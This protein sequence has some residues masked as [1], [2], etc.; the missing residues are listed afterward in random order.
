MGT[1][2]GGPNSSFWP[3]DG[4]IIGKDITWFHCVIWPC[5]LKSAGVPLN[6]SVFSHGFVTGKNGEKMSKSIGNVIDANDILDK[7]GADPFRFYMILQAPYGNDLAF[8]EE[9][10]KEMNDSILCSKFGNLL[11]RAIVLAQK[12]FGGKIPDVS[13][14]MFCDLQKLKRETDAA[15]K[16]FDLQKACQ[17][18]VNFL[19][20]A[21]TYHKEAKP[22]NKGRSDEERA[23]AVKT[24]VEAVYIG[25][26]FLAPYCPIAVDKTF[27]QLGV[28]QTT[29]KRL[30]LFNNIP[31]GLDLGSERP[32]VLFEQFAKRHLKKAA[33]AGAAAL[34]RLF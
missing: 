28:P 33:K 24:A 30:G 10:L 9:R 26:H 21:N 3:P 4:Q 32:K 5:M 25:A 27:K 14:D 12:Y 6:R 11:N 15:F 19:S 29:I 7:Y 2:E 22:W 20:A 31:A 17:L 13:A 34:L 8:D 16:S 23:V 1:N 18:A